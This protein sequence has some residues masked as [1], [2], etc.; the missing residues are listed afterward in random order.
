M[1]TPLAD[2]TTNLFHLRRNGNLTPALLHFLLPFQRTAPAAN[3]A[4]FAA[5]VLPP[6]LETPL[7]ARGIIHAAAVHALVRGNA[8]VEYPCQPRLDQQRHT[9]DL[10][11]AGS[12]GN[13]S[14]G[15]PIREYFRTMG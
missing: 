2:R 13:N 10:S 3:A 14:H 12:V 1:L 11:V 7:E 8:A 5:N 6:A 9:A 4:A 15:G